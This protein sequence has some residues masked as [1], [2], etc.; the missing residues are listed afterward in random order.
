MKLLTRFFQ[1]AVVITVVFS[2]LVALSAPVL[3][4]D[5]ARVYLQ[6][7]E[8]TDSQVTLDVIAENVSNMYGA[9]VQLKYDPAVVSVQDANQTQRRPSGRF[10]RI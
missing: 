6:I 2:S 1:I 10:C 8:S 7:V 9:E 3:A 5:A 4:Q